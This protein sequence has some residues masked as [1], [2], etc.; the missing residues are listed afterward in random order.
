[1]LSSGRALRVWSFR[2]AVRLVPHRWP[3]LFVA[4]AFV[5]ADY[6]WLQA[7]ALTGLAAAVAEVLFAIVTVRLLDRRRPAACWRRSGGSTS[8]TRRSR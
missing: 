2:S 8:W 1:M 3:I 5:Y 4:P 6:T 7:T